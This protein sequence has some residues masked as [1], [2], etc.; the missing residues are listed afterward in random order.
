MWAE[1][2]PNLHLIGAYIHCDEPDGT[3]HLHC[4]YIPVAECSRG[5]SI[6][7]SLDKEVSSD[8]I[9]ELVM[10]KLKNLDEVAYVR[11]ASVYRRFT[12]IQ[13]FK[14]ELDILSEQ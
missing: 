10:L 13:S 3:V 7:N 4:D 9:G 1:R 6:Q 5:M 12:D 2:N 8:R 11:F 14:K